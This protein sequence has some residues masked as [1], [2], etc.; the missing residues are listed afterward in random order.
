MPELA[1]NIRILDFLRDFLLIEDVDFYPA[2][3]FED[4][5]DALSLFLQDDEVEVINYRYG[6]GDFCRFEIGERRRILFDLF[7]RLCKSRL[8]EEMNSLMAHYENSFALPVSTLGNGT[9]AAFNL[10]TEGFVR[11]CL[12]MH[13]LPYHPGVAG[14][15]SYDSKI[16]DFP[17]IVWRFSEYEVRLD[18]LKDLLNRASEN[19]FRRLILL[20]MPRLTVSIPEE[21]EGHIPYTFL[22]VIEAER[23]AAP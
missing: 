11:R 15:F 8:F 2:R 10:E 20:A 5:E 12:S 17:V 3:M 21:V 19:G 4:F 18:L 16:G 22:P 14:D 6:D 9:E 13:G 7:A 23:S 1:Q